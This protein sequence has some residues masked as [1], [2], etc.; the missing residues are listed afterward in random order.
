MGKPSLEQPRG[1]RANHLNA[2]WCEPKSPRGPY[3][4]PLRLLLDSISCVSSLPR[5]KCQNPFVCLRPNQSSPE[6]PMQVQL[7]PL[8]WESEAEFQSRCDRHGDHGLR[9]S[10]FV[11][12]T[13]LQESQWDCSW[14]TP[15]PTP[16]P[17]TDLNSPSPSIV[18][19]VVSLKP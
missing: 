15:P 4:L 3:C 5:P 17:D 1:A 11:H 8:A 16:T 13:T 18:C 7:L 12:P 6:S 14:H 19:L 9:L 10:S 2:K